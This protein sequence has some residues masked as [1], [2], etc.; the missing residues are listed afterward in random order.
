[1][2]VPQKF[3]HAVSGNEVARV[4]YRLGPCPGGYG[5]SFVCTLG[6]CDCSIDDDL[7]AIQ[8]CHAQASIVILGD[9]SL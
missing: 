4:L 5:R 9:W 7:R 3:R 1:M 2:G 6:S 8:A